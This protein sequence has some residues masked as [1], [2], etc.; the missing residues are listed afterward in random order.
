MFE[1]L[2]Y[3][4]S[5]APLS[6]PLDHNKGYTLY[7]SAS[8]VAIVGVLVQ[9]GPNNREYVIYYINKNLYKHAL[10]HEL[11]ENT[12]LSIVHSVYKLQ[13]YIILQTITVIENINPM[14]YFFIH[15]MMNHKCAQW[16]V[17]L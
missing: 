1:A 2:K 12:S 4:L 13:H 3:A 17:I 15:H 5:Q 8:D 7:L 11:A 10:K 16:V 14:R 9:E 6:I